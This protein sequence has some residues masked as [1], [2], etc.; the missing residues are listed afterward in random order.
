VLCLPPSTRKP[1][2][3]AQR[4][5]ILIEDSS[6]VFSLNFRLVRMEVCHKGHYKPGRKSFGWWINGLSG[7][8]WCSPALG[9]SIVL[10]KKGLRKGLSLLA[11]GQCHVSV[12]L[13]HCTQ[14]SGARAWLWSL[15]H[16]QPQAAAKSGPNAQPS[17]LAGFILHLNYTGDRAPWAF[18]YSDTASPRLKPP[19]CV[20]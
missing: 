4:G 8:K 2:G 20:I 13:D 10:T 5:Q 7:A 6:C 3:G 18:N 15:Q 14:L 12:N 9:S 11:I 16:C 17:L 1:I 19:Y